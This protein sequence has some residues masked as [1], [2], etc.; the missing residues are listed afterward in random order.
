MVLWALPTLP[1]MLNTLHSRRSLS[2]GKIYQIYHVIIVLSSFGKKIVA[3]YRITF[4]L[5]SPPP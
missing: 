4:L 5:S 2:N 3:P 1:L